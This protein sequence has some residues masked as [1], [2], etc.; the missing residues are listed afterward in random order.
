MSK[1]IIAI[2]DDLAERFG[3][4]IDWTS[5]NVMPYLQELFAKALHGSV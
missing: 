4:A 5:A 3:V 1:E 2:F